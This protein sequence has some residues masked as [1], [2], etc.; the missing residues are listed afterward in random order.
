MVAPQRPPSG[1]IPPLT[2]NFDLELDATGLACPMP[3]VKTKKALAGM[4]S[5]QVLRVLSTDPDSV[6]DMQTFA[7]HT[8]N[9]LLASSQAN[10]RF[11]FLLKKA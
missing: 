4:A 1:H 2:M 5:G 8:G 6:A 3:I 11:I 10:D 7:E 9:A